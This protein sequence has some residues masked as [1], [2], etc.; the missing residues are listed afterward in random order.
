M[1]AKPAI[2][3]CGILFP[4]TQSH[5][6]RQRNLA[7]NTCS[8]ASKTTPS[9]SIKPVLLQPVLLT[10]PLTHL[11]LGVEDAM[12]WHI[13]SL[14]QCAEDIANSPYVVREICQRY[15][16]SIR[17]NLMRQECA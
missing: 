2:R 6:R 12:S 17:R 10:E 15:L 5:F 3:V 8:N 4:V 1:P 9:A 14:R 7:N 13:C 11:S 16:L